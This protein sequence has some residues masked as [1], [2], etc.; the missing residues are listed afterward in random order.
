MARYFKYTD[1]RGVCPSFMAEFIEDGTGDFE[2]W[3]WYRRINNRQKCAA[4][5][6][7]GEIEW[8]DNNPSVQT[9]ACTPSSTEKPKPKR[10]RRTKAE[11]KA[12]REQERLQAQRIEEQ[13]EKLRRRNR[14]MDLFAGIIAFVG[15][16]LLL[17]VGIGAVGLLAFFGA[18]GMLSKA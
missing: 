12:A 16:A 17:W 4:K 3:I 10:H 18:G 1:P 5:F 11:M 13:Q 14:E 8:I 2:G 6:C 9:T 7:P 15:V